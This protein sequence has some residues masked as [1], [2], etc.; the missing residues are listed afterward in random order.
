MSVDSGGR[1]S[2]AGR[3]WSAAIRAP[4]R[5]H[6]IESSVDERRM[7]AEA[8]REVDLLAARAF[9]LLHAPTIRAT[10]SARSPNPFSAAE[11]TP[12][13]LS[14]TRRNTHFPA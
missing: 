2:W 12:F 11:R 4:P 1:C 13:R 14:E 3:S 5:A 9:D 7:I 6:T 10:P 8:L